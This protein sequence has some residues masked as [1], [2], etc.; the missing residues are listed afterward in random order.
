MDYKDYKAGMT[1]KHFWFQGKA[2][3]IDVLLSKLDSNK[4]LKI[5]DIGAGTGQDLEVI[6][7]YGSV[8]VLDIEQNALDLIPDQ[9]VQDKKLGD[10]C[11]IPYSD[12]S[13]DLVVSF[14]VL[15]H[16]PDDK[17]VTQEV[18][19]VLK[20][21]GAF[22]FTVPA[23]K[24]LYGNH[25]RELGHARRYDKKLIRSLLRDNF[26]Q[27]SLGFWLFFLFLPA[28]I[29][30]LFN[31]N[32]VNSGKKMPR[33]INTIFSK[34]LSFENWLISKGLNFPLGLSVYGIY[35]VKK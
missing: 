2:G 18:A 4:N 21:G 8:Y 35:K 27:E 19:R 16:I 34:V 20:P 6:N 10:A 5:L 29:Q 25:D 14:D 24:F 12:N 28:S 30:R 13:F 33:F 26:K 17:K 23:F 1:E 3:L 11:F 9:M 15:E 32:F 22:I 31:L 7:K